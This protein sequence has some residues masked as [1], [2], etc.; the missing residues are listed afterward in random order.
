MDGYSGCCF[1][2]RLSVFRMAVQIRYILEEEYSK[3]DLQN[4]VVRI[5]IL[6]ACQSLYPILRL[7]KPAI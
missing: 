3:D 7:Q 6:L 5:E 4:R 2:L 1:M